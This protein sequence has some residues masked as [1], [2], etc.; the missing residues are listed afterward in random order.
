MLLPFPSSSQSGNVPICITPERKEPMMIFS[1]H[2]LSRKKGRLG[3]CSVSFFFSYPQR[4]HEVFKHSLHKNQLSSWLAWYWDLGWTRNSPGK[5]W[6]SPAFL[7]LVLLAVDT[8]KA[9]SGLGDPQLKQSKI[10]M[11]ETLA[12]WGK[13]YVTRN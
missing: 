9:T 3:P 8:F 10:Y 7:R 11:T 6:W 12:M 2:L 4:L 5:T 13:C 1:C